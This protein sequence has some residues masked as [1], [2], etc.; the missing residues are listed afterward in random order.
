MFRHPLD[1]VPFL[2][3]VVALQLVIA[4]RV[5]H[6]DVAA[7]YELGPAKLDGPI[8]SLPVTLDVAANA[9]EQ[10]V[11]FSLDVSASDNQLTTDGTD[12]T[13]FGFVENSELL[14]GWQQ[15]PQ[16]GFGL[17]ERQSSI[18]FD[19]ITS[20][21]DPGRYLLGQLAIDLSQVPQP[22]LPVTVSI[23]AMGSAIGAEIPGDPESFD[24][25]KPTFQP[26]SVTIPEPSGL[27]ATLIGLL[28]LGA[29]FFHRRDG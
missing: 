20:P 16:T 8:A 25:V 27:L 11:Y 24:F 28:V 4:H 9:G 29:F 5:A 12:F 7:V 18:E 2:F 6:A 26:E 14:P 13:R 10:V 19:T 23:S 17:G 22:N 15:I 21:L 3:A 1:R